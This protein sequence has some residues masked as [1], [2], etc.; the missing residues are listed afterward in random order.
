[1]RGDLQV[2]KGNG[3]EW[4][5]A[6]GRE[7]ERPPGGLWTFPWLALR[8]SKRK[9]LGEECDTSWGGAGAWRRKD[10]ALLLDAV[11]RDQKGHPS[12]GWETGWLGTDTNI[13]TAMITNTCAP[14]AAPSVPAMAMRWRPSPWVYLW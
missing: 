13:T 12:Q 5:F 2:D 1:M 9:G 8:G 10:N 4:G 11:T 14:S 3:V 6:G 7:R